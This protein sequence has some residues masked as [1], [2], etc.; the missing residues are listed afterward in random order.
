MLTRIVDRAPPRR[1]TGEDMTDCDRRTFLAQAS[2]A[3]AAMALVPDL[4]A[5]TETVDGSNLRVGVVGAGRQGR[6]I[7]GELQKIE[8]LTI[9]AICDADERRLSSGARRAPGAESFS[10]HGAMLEKKTD[11]NVVFIATPDPYAQSHRH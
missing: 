2:T 4:L 6:T 8:G 1:G 11:M 9:V 5:S 7:L 3:V 10:D